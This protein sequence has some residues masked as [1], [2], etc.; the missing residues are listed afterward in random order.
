MYTYVPFWKQ[1][2]FIRLLIPLITGILIQWHYTFSFYNICTIGACSL[3]AFI[4]MHFLNVKNIF[5]FGWV[6]GLLLNTI[7]IT[8]GA[9]LVFQK[10]IRNN[11]EWIGNY[12]Q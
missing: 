6:T 12:Y 5:R 7:L 4:G 2:P 1:H 11:Q 8:L 3:L 10:D 9:L